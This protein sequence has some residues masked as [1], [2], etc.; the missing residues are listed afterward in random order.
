MIITLLISCLLTCC[1]DSQ[2]ADKTNSKISKPKIS[3][4]INRAHET[5]TNKI[6]IIKT[7]I[8]I[9]NSFTAKKSCCKIRSCHFVKSLTTFLNGTSQSIII[10]FTQTRH[11]IPYARKI[12][13]FYIFTCL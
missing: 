4:T 11:Y 3:K 9:S 2:V 7:I 6:N 8:I 12:N 1:G 5:K 10:A 13:P